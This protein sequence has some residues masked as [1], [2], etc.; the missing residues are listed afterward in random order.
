MR[1]GF[2]LEVWVSRYGRID[3]LNSLIFVFFDCVKVN[4]KLV[5]V[6]V[7]DLFFG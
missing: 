3:T 6:L 4:L 7:N 1:L 5:V 2:V